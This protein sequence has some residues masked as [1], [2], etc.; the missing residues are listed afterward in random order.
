MVSVES[1]RNEEMRRM[2]RLIGKKDPTF[3]EMGAKE[4]VMPKQSVGN[5]LPVSH[6]IEFVIETL[7]AQQ[8][9][10]TTVP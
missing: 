4:T 1:L 9:G 6:S 8:M 2:K 7:T 3:V 10:T 5:M